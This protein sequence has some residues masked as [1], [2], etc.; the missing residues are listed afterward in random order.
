MSK[1]QKIVRKNNSEVYSVNLP[2]EVIENVGWEKGQNLD[3]KEDG[4]NVI[5]SKKEEE[6]KEEDGG[7]DEESN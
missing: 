1:L 2:L 5:I 4:E 3:V 7:S 6:E